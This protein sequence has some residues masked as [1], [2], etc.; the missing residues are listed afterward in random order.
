MDNGNDSVRKPTM[1]ILTNL[2]NFYKTGPMIIDRLMQTPVKECH[3]SLVVVN[4]ELIRIVTS[5]S[6]RHLLYLQQSKKRAAT[7]Y[8]YLGTYLRFLILST[9]H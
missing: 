3:K 9:I 1:K 2:R 6:F 4:K 8:L 7:E 5:V